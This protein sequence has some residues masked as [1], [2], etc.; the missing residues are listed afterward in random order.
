MQV[1]VSASAR[2]P[3][4]LAHQAAMAQGLGVIG[5]EPVMNLGGPVQTKH[6]ACWGW[7][8]GKQLRAAGH[9]VLVMERGYIGDR[10]EHTS[11]G[12]NGLNGHATFPDVPVTP[13]R[14][15]KLASL[16]PWKQGGD[17]V[18]ILG[19][20]PGD[21]SLQGRDMMPL[22]AEWA[23]KAQT[24]Y[25][26]PVQFRM[27]PRA[28]EKGYRQK[29]PG[30]EPSGGPLDDALAGALVAICWNSN[31]AVDAVL[32]GVP[33]VTLDKGSM[34]WDVT[35][36]RIGDLHRPAR[37]TWAH[38]LA[39]KQWALDEIRSGVALVPLFEME[40]AHGH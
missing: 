12:W 1:T 14:F 28:A 16:K 15:D 19:Q 7:R 2:A 30:T 26:S 24:A 10:F 27:H 36:H 39:H 37:E 17:Y 22:Y 23:M 13:E 40:A 21:A 31:S 3:H 25:E 5:I 20:V 18:L 8:Q 6:V 34:A 29:V 11:L 9:E 35:A 38:R 32:A 4:Q 33:T